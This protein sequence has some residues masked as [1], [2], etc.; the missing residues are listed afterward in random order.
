MLIWLLV[1]YRTW[2]LVHLPLQ[3]SIHFGSRTWKGIPHHALWSPATTHSLHIILGKDLWSSIL[4]TL[5]LFEAETDVF[6]LLEFGHSLFEPIYPCVPSSNSTIL[7]LHAYKWSVGEKV[8]S[9]V[10]RVFYLSVYWVSLSGYVFPIFL[11]NP[12]GK[13]RIRL[14]W[15]LKPLF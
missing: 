6:P 14:V 8:M 10:L 12:I 5:R 9:S 13:C 3:W 11:I 15:S 2:N 1:E 4:G 7:L